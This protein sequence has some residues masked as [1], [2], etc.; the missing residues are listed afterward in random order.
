MT[1][2][3]INCVNKT[4]NLSLNCK[5]FVDIVYDK[6]YYPTNNLFSFLFNNTV[7]ILLHRVYA[8]CELSL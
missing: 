2:K 3:E 7:D 1:G 4:Q 8:E 6:Y 5:Q